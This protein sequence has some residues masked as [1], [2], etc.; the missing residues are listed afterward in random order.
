V[1]EKMHYLGLLE[2]KPSDKMLRDSFSALKGYN[3]IERLDGNWTSPETR[4]IIYPSIIFLVT[5]EKIC[6]L[7]DQLG[8]E[9][10]PGEE[11]EDETPGEDALD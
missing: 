5:N 9:E 2:R 10:A 6:A 7:Y 1:V 11:D 3:I 4:L 8:Q